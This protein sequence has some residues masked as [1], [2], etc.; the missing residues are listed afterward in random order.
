MTQHI[1]TPQIL[2][3]SE[4]IDSKMCL[5]PPDSGIFITFF[6]NGDD[7]EMVAQATMWSHWQSDYLIYFICN[8]QSV[9]VPTNDYNTLTFNISVANYIN[10]A[11]HQF[12]TVI[13]NV[14]EE[15][16][17]LCMAISF[18]IMCIFLCVGYK[19]YDD[20]KPIAAVYMIFLLFVGLLVITSTTTYFFMIYVIGFG[21]SRENVVQSFIM[22]YVYENIILLCLLLFATLELCFVLRMDAYAH[23]EQQR[24]SSHSVCDWYIASC[25]KILGKFRWN[26]FLLTPIMLLSAFHI[27]LSVS[28]DLVDVI[29]DNCSYSSALCNVYYYGDIN[30]VVTD[31]YGLL[32]MILICFCV[33]WIETRMLKKQHSCYLYL[34]LLI[35]VLL[36]LVFGVIYV[37]VD[38]S[39]SGEISWYSLDST[40]RYQRYEDGQEYAS[41]VLYVVFLVYGIRGLSMMFG[42]CGVSKYIVIGWY[43]VGSILYMSNG[44]DA[45]YNGAYVPLLNIGALVSVLVFFRD[46]KNKS[47]K[48]VFVIIS[49]FLQL[50]DVTTDWN[51]IY[52]WYNN[53]Y[54][55]WA[56]I[57]IMIILFAQIISTSKMG[58][59]D[60]ILADYNNRKNSN[61]NARNGNVK[62]AY[63][64]NEHYGNVE[65]G[66]CDRIMTSIGFGRSWVAA[67]LI[68]EREKYYGE[69]TNLKIY[70]LCLESIPTVVFQLYT[71]LIQTFV[72]PNDNTQVTLLTLIASIAITILSVSFSIWRVFASNTP[73]KKKQKKQKQN[74]SK[75]NNCKCIQEKFKQEI[76]TDTDT[77]HDRDVNCPNHKPCI[78][79]LEIETKS[80]IKMYS[81]SMLF[82]IYVLICCDLYIRSFPLI[83]GS[84]VIRTALQNTDSVNMDGNFNYFL[85]ISSIVMAIGVIVIGIYEYTMLLVIKRNE[86]KRMNKF[87]R[88]METFISLFTSL[89]SLLLTLPLKHFFQKNHFQRYLLFFVVCCLLFLMI[90]IITLDMHLGG[91]LFL[92]LVFFM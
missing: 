91:V 29:L 54:H 86:Y 88:L 56:I 11:F 89:L 42:F 1:Y 84:F 8:T 45:L 66:K 20:K 79:A 77:T 5:N 60:N 6:N 81:K 76:D 37:V 9:T 4:E 30:R 90:T 12:D 92:C 40:D 35:L 7:D 75:C 44:G 68:Q 36:C 53:G 51:L 80:K 59:V 14:G 27:V 16:T 57:Q 65:F 28:H 74:L 2:F 18:V 43:S 25:Q 32:M 24:G 15:S 82:V 67:K 85:L 46:S 55:S 62:T 23:D 26:L 87:T 34:C 48:I 49:M 33:I 22:Q 58:N 31:I 64:N 17:V 39:N 41:Y 50:M 52:Q 69:Y 73:T 83:F 47:S 70:E 3:I 10:N 72:I 19:G 61:A 21:C 38:I 71:A 13:Y 78:D 63:I